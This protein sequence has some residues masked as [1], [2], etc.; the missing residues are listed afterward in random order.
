MNEIISF[1]LMYEQI[2][3]A[4][5]DAF[6]ILMV[7][8]YPNC[9][10]IAVFDGLGGAGGTIYT[11]NEEEHTAAYIASRMVRNIVYDHLQSLLNKLINEESFSCSLIASELKDIIITRMRYAI[12]D[13]NINIPS[14]KIKSALVQVL[15]TTMAMLLFTKYI[16]NQ[17]IT[18]NYYSI[19]AG[20]SR[21]YILTSDY[22]L[23]QVTKDDISQDKD[24]FELLKQD[25][26]LS[27]NI[28][29]SEDFYIN[30]KKI[31]SDTPMILIS[32]TDGCFGYLPTPLHFE[33]FIL[34]SLFKSNNVLEW[35]DLLND[36][37][38]LYAGDDF[39]LSLVVI[40]WNDLD[41]L[42][43]NFKK[44]YEYCK[45]RVKGIDIVKRNIE[46]LSKHELFYTNRLWELYRSDYEHFIRD[47]GGDK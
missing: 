27:N 10:A 3:G 44:R 19:W 38:K 34:D 35:R 46:V 8:E 39:S 26:P 22:G 4:G 5:E 16:N 20:D 1:D 17:T 15:P 47:L 41:I 36:I 31:T 37:I 18:Y 7:D 32:A 14:S 28:K 6:P 2:S 42:K 9:G 29:F 12:E 11:V 24:A 40:E 23:Q 45:V 33:Y 13:K 21:N 25:C 30:C 43:N